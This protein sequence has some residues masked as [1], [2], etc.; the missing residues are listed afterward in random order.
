MYCKFCGKEIN[1][2]SNFCP[3]CGGSFADN[4]SSVNDRIQEQQNTQFIPSTPQKQG[5][6]VTSLV[7][8]IA[9]LI[10]V[11]FFY[12]SIPCAFIGKNLGKEA[13][14][15]N[16]DERQYAQSGI[17]LCDI[18]IKIGCVIAVIYVIVFAVLIIKK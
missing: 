1:D 16:M 12:I 8:G 9:S 18:A 3:S 15:Q 13:I 10:L 6:A 14:R 2:N 11:L 17:K 7:L 5:L 4:I